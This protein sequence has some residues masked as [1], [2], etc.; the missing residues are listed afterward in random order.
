MKKRIIIA[1]IAVLL[2]ACVSYIGYKIFNDDEFGAGY[3][4]RSNKMGYLTTYSTTT[5]VAG[6]GFCAGCPVKILDKNINRRYAWI[7]NNSSVDIYLFST[8]T[9]LD[10]SGTG[11]D[12]A[13]TTSIAN[14]NGIRIAAND[15]DNMDDVYVID[16]SNMIY[17]HLWASSTA[18][19][20]AKE[21]I[22]NYYNSPN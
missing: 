17:G 2:V 14:L 19:G 18:D 8:T 12:R 13:A 9:T 15:G 21:I 4:S 16:Q 5:S 20:V 6:A 11:A 1:I 3:D 22:V 7:H 10:L